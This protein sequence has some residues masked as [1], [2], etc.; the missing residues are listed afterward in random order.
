MS[1][2]LLILIFFMSYFTVG[3]VSPYYKKFNAP[4]GTF[5]K[6]DINGDNILAYKHNADL[7]RT[8][9]EINTQK[10]LP[11]E[12]LLIA[13]HCP[14]AYALLQ[15]KSPLWDIYFLFEETQDRQ[16]QMISE[17]KEKKV[18]WVILG[19]IALDGRDDLRFKNTHH[20]LWQHFMNNFKPVHVD[21]LP[22]THQL[23]RRET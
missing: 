2:G 8:L 3:M 14:G 12:N 13:P 11:G 9:T 20:L 16:N 6:T 4:D 15:R 19:D 22:D 21:G 1:T 17:L 5:A 18:N 23:L 10:I 7:I